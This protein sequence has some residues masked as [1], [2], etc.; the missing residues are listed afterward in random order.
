VGGGE[1]KGKKRTSR[2]GEAAR[3]GAKI[4]VLPETAV[5]GYLSQD[6]KEN[7]HVKGLPLDDSFTGKD[8]AG[9]AETVPGPSTRHFAAL[10]KELRIYLTIPLLEVVR[11]AG[12]QGAPP[13][14]NTVCLASPE[15]KLAAH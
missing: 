1:E 14:F 8:P 9:F 15:A 6:L 2:A 5:T 7:W 4:V 10:A 3:R 13:Y 11:P 12:G